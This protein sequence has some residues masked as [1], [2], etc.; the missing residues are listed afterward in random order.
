MLFLYD[1]NMH[2]E[3]G[4]YHCARFDS[5]ITLI[6]TGIIFDGLLC[7]G[8]NSFSSLLFL[9]SW[10]Y[11]STRLL[12]NRTKKGLLFIKGRRRI[13]GTVRDD[14]TNRQVTPVFIDNNKYGQE[15]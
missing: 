9:Q 2:N 6:P 10:A 12:G 13:Y 15:S 3:S 7:G 11:I 1:C 14:I 5:F 4:S 8:V